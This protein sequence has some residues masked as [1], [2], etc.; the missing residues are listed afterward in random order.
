MKI[1]YNWLKQYISTELT[2]SEISELLTDIGLEVESI[3]EFEPIKGGLK[4]IVV[5]KVLNCVK[6][7][8]ADRLHVTKV[9]IGQAE[10]L[11]IVCGAPNVAEGQTV[12]VAT[13]GTKLYSK[14]GSDFEIKRSKIRG[15]PS[16]G[17]ICAEDE[18]GLGNSHAGIMVLSS[19]IP[20]GTLGSDLYY[21]KNDYVYEIGLTPNRSDAM[22]HFGVARDLAAAIQCRHQSLLTANL[23]NID[24]FKPELGKNPISV[25]LKDFENCPRYSGL[26]IDHLKI[27]ESPDWLKNSLKSM[28]LNPINNIVDI[29]NF[30][31][32]E[33]GQPLHAFDSKKLAN[34]SIIVRKANPQ[35]FTTLDGVERQLNGSELMICDAE[36]ELCIAGVFGGLDSG[37]SSITTSIFLESAFFNPVSIRKS[38]KLHGLKTDSSFRFE[39]GADPEITLYALKR[40]ALL[41]SEL[42]PD[43]KYSEISDTYPIPLSKPKITLN[44]ENLWSLVGKKIP[45]SVIKTI[46]KSLDFEI[47]QETESSF[48]LNSP[49][50]R[51]DVTREADVIEEILRIYGFNSIE[52]P[53]KL[54]YTL[55]SKSELMNQKVKYK[56]TISNWLSSNGFYESINNSLTKSDYFEKIEFLKKEEAVQ[57]LNPLSKELEFMRQSL[58]P[59][60]L[61]NILLNQNYQNTNVRLFE[62]GKH[63]N[64]F[65]LFKENDV[66]RKYKEKEFLSIII[67]GSENTENWKNPIYKS[68]FYTIKSII[69]Q[70]VKL[71]NIQDKLSLKSFSD[72]QFKEGI[73]YIDYSNQ[74]V[75]KCGIIH[76]KLLKYFDVKQ[77]VFYSEIDWKLFYDLSTKKT[78][79]YSELINFQPV[80]RDLALLIDKNVSFDEIK[81]I[82]VHCIGRLLKE[83]NIFDVYEGDKIPKDKKSYA[84]SFV[85]QDKEKTMTDIEINIVMNKLIKAFKTSIN[86]ELR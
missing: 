85:F 77:E 78:V 16:E 71:S 24:S 1:S 41:I 62:F 30:I 31:M 14:D 54:N 18:L 45:V 48:E 10:H 69:E 6:H 3:E 20:A 70:L 12:L 26:F 67:C 32:L 9:N 4:G 7:P 28:G 22:S 86:A 59:G 23:P 13:I 58:L 51:T 68:D 56:E 25:E 40:A 33:T 47:L 81:K 65:S 42:C 79:K 39:R 5:G 60:L 63:Y 43:A 52:I 46:L 73:A 49:L 76:P 11:Q 61:E 15:L 21:T 53:E 27:G 55:L 82:A 80:R 38:S 72:N 64:Y 66:T 35:K 29:T 19:D 57:L 17:M 36:K 44:I 8:D 2:V 84:L 37:V 50:Y 75:L 34:Q 83:I 74:T